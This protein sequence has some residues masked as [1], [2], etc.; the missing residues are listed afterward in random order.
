L[1]FIRDYEYIVLNNKKDANMMQTCV[2]LKKTEIRAFFHG[3]SRMP[4]AVWRL[5]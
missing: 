5:G 3:R 2:I 1:V 4:E